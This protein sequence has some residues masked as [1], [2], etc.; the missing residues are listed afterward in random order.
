MDFKIAV[1]KYMPIRGEINCER[2]DLNALRTYID[3]IVENESI[4]Q[5]SWYAWSHNA[6][7]ADRDIIEGSLSQKKRV[8][9]VSDDNSDNDGNNNEYAMI[10]EE[11]DD[12]ASEDT[13]YIVLAF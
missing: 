8:N 2:Q 10:E 7:A 9:C 12:D 13:C 4:V 5:T 6:N 11:D 3:L 1:A